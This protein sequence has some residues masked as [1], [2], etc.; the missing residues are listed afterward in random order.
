MSRPA[1]PIIY[2]DVNTS[3]LTRSA[4]I[5]PHGNPSDPGMALLLDMVAAALEEFGHADKFPSL[6]PNVYAGPDRWLSEEA[7]DDAA[8]KARL[9]EIMAHSRKLAHPR[10]IAHMDSSAPATAALGG[11]IVAAVLKNNLLSR[12]MAPALSKLEDDVLREL[13]AEFGWRDGGGTILACGSLTNLQALA[14]ARNVK[15]NTRETG[16]HGLSG[17]PVLFA[18]EAAHS[19]LQKSAMVLG[20]GSAGVIA[21]KT[22]AASRMDADDLRAKIAAAQAAGKLPFAVVATIGSTITG[23]IDPIETIADIAQESGLWFHADAVFGGVAHFSRQHRYR[24]RGIERAD[25]VNLNLH[26]WLY[27]A[28]AGSILLFR[29][30]Q[31]LLDQFRIGAPYMSAAH[32]LNL[33]EI[34]IQGSRDPYV[35][36]LAL[37]LFHLGR[38]GLEQLIDEG[39]AYTER[40]VGQLR[41]WPWIEFAGETDTNLVAFRIVRKGIGATA[42]DAL[43]SSLQEHLYAQGRFAVS[44]SPY[45]GAKWV[46]LVFQNVHFG[47]R[48]LEEL[49]A[50]IE[51][52]AAASGCGSREKPATQ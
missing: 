5:S 4:F 43:N 40:F 28:Q 3:L 35:L 17:Q 36:G 52:F 39:Y 18:S 33:G 23:A 15:L 48:D 26:K 7:G 13:A 6:P 9:A 24:V 30:R 8:L 14:V 50:E 41:Q 34:S 31:V 20:L 29:D 2:G 37:S 51:R 21:V 19:S 27:Q 25:S 1:V 49:I 22:D 11:T 32:G 12:E 45:R 42:L 47:E 44:L 38:R 10:Y 46:R 16:I